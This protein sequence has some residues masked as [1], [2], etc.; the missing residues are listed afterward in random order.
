AVP[1]ITPAAVAATIP[2]IRNAKHALNAADRATDARANCTTDH[3]TNW[4]GR[5]VTLTRALMATALHPS[6]DTLRMRKMRNG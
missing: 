1:P 2:A 5:T 6:D 3:A 4:A